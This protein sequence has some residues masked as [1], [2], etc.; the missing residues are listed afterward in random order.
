MRYWEG[1]VYYDC[2]KGMSLLIIM[3][4]MW[5]VDGEF[6]VFDY[7]FVDYVIKGYYGQDHVHVAYVIQLAVDTIQYRHLDG[8]RSSLSQIMQVFFPHKN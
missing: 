7:P 8:K 2:K 4:I 5:K 3:E 1:Q 6:S